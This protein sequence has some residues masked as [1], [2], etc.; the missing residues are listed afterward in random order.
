MS[1]LAVLLAVLFRG[2]SR[3]L[4]GASRTVALTR[5]AVESLA[6]TLRNGLLVVFSP[7]QR[8]E[9]IVQIEG[10]IQFGWN[11]DPKEFELRTAF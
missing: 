9:V 3:L 6:R 8:F 1:M 2:L 7:G 5:T 10:E 4:H 11:V